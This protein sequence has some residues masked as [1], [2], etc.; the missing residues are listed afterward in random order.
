[1]WQMYDH[2]FD[3]SY[4][5]ALSSPVNSL[6]RVDDLFETLEKD[7]EFLGIVAIEDFIEDFEVKP[8]AQ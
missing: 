3:F 2:Y 5:T 8:I 7:S 6:G 1:M 4:Q